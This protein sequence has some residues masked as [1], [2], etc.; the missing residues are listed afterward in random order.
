MVFGCNLVFRFVLIAVDGSLVDGWMSSWQSGKAIVLSCDPK[1]G[2]A[3]DG[4]VL[5]REVL[6][7]ILILSLSSRLL[8]SVG[9]RPRQ[10]SVHS[11]V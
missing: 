10:K 3:D 1:S 9:V 6:I 11:G 5:T 7:L 8:E 4:G 2:K